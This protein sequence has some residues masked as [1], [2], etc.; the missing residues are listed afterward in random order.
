M[1]RFIV[2]NDKKCSNSEEGAGLNLF[3]GKGRFGKTT[4]FRRGFAEV[5]FIAR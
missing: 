5:S 4:V 1:A 3:D 2:I